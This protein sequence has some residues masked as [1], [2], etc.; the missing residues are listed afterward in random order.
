MFIFRTNSLHNILCSIPFDSP[1]PLGALFVHHL[2]FGRCQRVLII[3]YWSL[4]GCMTS[5]MLTAHIFLIW[6]KATYP[7]GIASAHEPSFKTREKIP[8]SVGTRT[9]NFLH[10]KLRNLSTVMTLKIDVNNSS[11]IET[12][13]KLWREIVTAILLR[14]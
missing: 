5:I 11:S 6:V 9:R 12:N 1:L 7:L 13:L 14:N 4:R 3:Y 2:L 10:S 8:T